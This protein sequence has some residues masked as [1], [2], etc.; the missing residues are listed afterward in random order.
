MAKLI[1][2]KTV[3]SY[4]WPEG[5]PRHLKEG[6]MV[7]NELYEQAVVG[8]AECIWAG[9]PGTGRILYLITRKDE[10]GAWGIV[11][12]DTIR[13]LRPSEVR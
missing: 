11:L 4:N 10:R 1:Y 12:E 3:F 6:R 2:P 7:P 5:D 13:E 8:K 9:A